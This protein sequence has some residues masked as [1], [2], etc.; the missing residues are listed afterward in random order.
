MKKDIKLDDGSTADRDFHVVGIGASAGGLEALQQLL[1]SV[2]INTG[3]AFVIVPH[4]SPDYKSALVEI[5][6]KNTKI[7][8]SEIAE[9][10]LVKP[11]HVYVISPNHN[12]SIRDGKLKLEVLQESTRLRLPID[13]FLNSLA[14][15]KRNRAI[16]VILSGTG[17]DGTKGLKAIKAEGGITFAQREETAKFSDMPRNA[18]ASGNVDYVLSPLDIARKLLEIK[19]KLESLAKIAEEYC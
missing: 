16:G 10:S 13:H 17:S 7:P 8:V 19:P 6:S 3:M 12:L 15:Q 5:L 11:D 18:I 4:L 1:G 9:D 2:S 14:E